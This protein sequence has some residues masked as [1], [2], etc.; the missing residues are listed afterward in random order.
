VPIAAVL[1]LRSERG[2]GGPRYT[3]LGTA[4]LGG[5]ETAR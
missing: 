2:P 4:R 5:E 1:L 3:V